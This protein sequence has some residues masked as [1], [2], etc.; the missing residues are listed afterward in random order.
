M[1]LIEAR[2]GII[3]QICAKQWLSARLMQEISQ[4][5]IIVFA[6]SKPAMNFQSRVDAT[7]EPPAVFQLV[8]DGV[9]A[10][11]ANAV[12]KA[13]LSALQVKLNKIN[14]QIIINKTSAWYRVI[15]HFCEFYWRFWS[16]C[17]VLLTWYQIYT[18]DAARMGNI[19]S[20]CACVQRTFGQSL[21]ADYAK[22]ANSRWY[23]ER[24]RE[25]AIESD[26][27]IRWSLAL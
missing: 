2:F 26:A 8:P 20:P 6:G 15:G 21:A 14:S 5:K 24:R 10:G 22:W 13:S 25:Y 3:S 19:S 7:V 27:M 23:R 1:S 11:T 17:L 4:G 18:S 9:L 16:K 12:I